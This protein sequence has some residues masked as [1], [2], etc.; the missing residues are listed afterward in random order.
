METASGL[1]E[2]TPPLSAA[3]LDMLTLQYKL[4]SKTVKWCH[5][6]YCQSLF[7]HSFGSR[8]QVMVHV[9]TEGCAQLP[10]GWKHNTA[11]CLG[12]IQAPLEKGEA[13]R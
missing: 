6:G 3:V 12:L 4:E 10:K 5:H 2:I 11:I 1:N 8:V 7:L 9:Y 13:P